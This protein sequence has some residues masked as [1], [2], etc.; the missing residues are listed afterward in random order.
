MAQVAGFEGWILFGDLTS[1]EDILVLEWPHLN[2]GS[3][4]QGERSIKCSQPSDRNICMHELLEN[5]R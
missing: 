4:H 2:P 1:Q 5:L 3:D